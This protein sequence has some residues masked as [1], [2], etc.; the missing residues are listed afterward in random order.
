MA[1][2]QKSTPADLISRD[3]AASLTKRKDIESRLQRAEVQ[4][5]QCRTVVDDL[6]HDAADDAAVAAALASKRAAEDLVTAWQKSLDDVNEKILDLEDAT[7]EIANQKL[8]AE[9]AAAIRMIMKESVDDSAALNVAIEKRIKSARRAAALVPDAAGVV[10][11]LLNAK[12]ELPLADTLILQLLESRAV[13]TVAGTAPAALAVPEQPAPRQNVVVE[14]APTFERV[15][16]TQNVAWYGP[17]GT[18]HCWPSLNDAELPVGPVLAK[19]RTIG[20]AWA[21]NS[22]QRKKHH[23]GKSN[24]KPPLEHCKFLNDDPRLKSN[25][26]PIKSSHLGNPQPMDRGP[27]YNLIVP[28]QPL[29]VATRTEK[30]Q[31]S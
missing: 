4:A 22:E 27:G 7:A 21:M 3:L 20:A 19:A 31:Q 25:V 2:F 6:T 1:L 26:A 5:A 10:G 16:L 9:T 29:Q 13:A 8:R 18:I 30:P 12:S 24:A 23:G 17:D 14:L 15:F 28:S 11:Y